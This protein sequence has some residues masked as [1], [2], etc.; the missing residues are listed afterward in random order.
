MTLANGHTLLHYRLIEKIGEGGMGV[1]WSARDTALDREVAVKVLPEAVA[2]DSDRLARFEREAKLLASLNHPNVA[3]VYGLHRDGATHFLAMERV[4]GDDL[5]TRLL[6]G[7]LPL[8]EV[9]AVARG[10]ADALEAAHE[11][12][13]IHRDLKPANVKVAPDGT[14]KV[15]DFGLAKALDTVATSGDP[16][17]PTSSPT[18]TSA[19]TIAG[20]ILGTAAYMSPE[21]ARGKPLDRRTDLWS[22]G[23][24]LYEMLTGT[25]PFDGETITDVLSA[26]ISKEPGRDALPPA[27]PAALRRLLDR[28][29]EKDPRRRLADASTAR[30][31]LD[32]ALRELRAPTTPAA[33]AAGAP[34]RRA[35][36]PWA[37]A[38]V[39]VVVAVAWTLRPAA[40]PASPAPA[41]TAIEALTDRRGAEF[42]PAISPDGRSLAYVARDGDDLDI[43]LVRVGGENPINLTANHDGQDFAPAF[44]PDGERIAFASDREGGGLFVMGAT[45][46]S[47]RRVAPE[48]SHP[49]WSPDGTK[50]VA[51]TEQVD[52]PYVRWTHG[53]VFVVDLAT[54]ERRD[55]PV[56]EDGVGPRWSPDGRRIAYWNEIDGRR[57]L[58][59][60]G[61]DDPAPVR[62]TD[63]AH[64]DWE[65][66]WAEGGRALY[67]HSDRGGNPDLWRVAIDPSTGAAAGP[68]APLTIGPT[69]AWESSLSADGT[70]LVVAMRAKR[71]AVRAYRFD[72]R[73]ARV[74]GPATTLLESGSGLTQ[75]TVSADG[76]RLA[77]RTTHPREIV[78][79]LDLDTGERRRL[80][81]D[82]FRNRGPQ[83]S[84]DGRWIAIYTNRSGRYEV[85]RMQPEGTDVHRLVDA[86]AS[87]PEWSP[88]GALLAVQ[89]TADD[90]RIDTAFY[91]PDPGATA[92]DS[93]WIEA[94]ERIAGFVSLAWSRDGRYLAGAVG[95]P[96]TLHVRDL[97]TDTFVGAD[98]PAPIGT[99]YPPVW[100]PDGER[101][102]FWSDERQ[103]FVTW[104]F[105]T[106]ATAPVAG[107]ESPPGEPR[108]APD[109]RTLYVLEDDVDGEVWMLTLERGNGG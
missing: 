84:P 95:W 96:W 72:A 99:A 68:P 28:C 83:W 58:W 37:I 61:L 57:D 6:R 60:I 27:T 39:A 16:S 9:I 40:A 65:P 38:A 108:L 92:S 44:S 25:R 21:Q 17:D 107:L 52:D 50:L 78:T 7:A 62:V 47:P 91:A 87:H 18:R 1:V 19:G 98:D 35:V 59:T 43:F 79:T 69:A 31:E 81:D 3:A 29:L 80:T 71:S 34:S 13:V 54:G 41:V 45:G 74:L 15:L 14:V 4:A 103:R 86:A 55:L 104:N 20:L 70:R 10:I 30:L 102:L 5:S 24:V 63:D 51:S 2:G 64:T 56:V 82:G 33:T 77:Y 105:R 42:M 36:L 22:F 90:G 26:V 48:G 100:L 89:I 66:L 93:P 11:G 76:R 85:W 32:E 12:G 94:R 49:D 101:L 106:G 67:F 97:H 53:R 73:A 46:E 8:D 88:V 75:M 109:G 23:C